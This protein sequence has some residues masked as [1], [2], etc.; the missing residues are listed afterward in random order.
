METVG[1]T[2]R[3]RFFHKPQYRV[4]KR[5]DVGINPYKTMIG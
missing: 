2:S 5:V 1:R 3:V 4:G